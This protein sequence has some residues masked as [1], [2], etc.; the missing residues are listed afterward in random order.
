[1]SSK[2]IS[3]IKALVIISS[4]DIDKALTGL[5]WATNALK[6]K[7]ASDVKVIFFGPIEKELSLGNK[8]LLDALKNYNIVSN[9]KTVACKFIAEQNNFLNN[10]NLISSQMGIDVI[11][12]GNKVAFLLSQG[13]IPLVF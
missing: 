6:Y 12:A 10:L 3:N 11:Y 13:Y 7:W 1:M 8:R 5:L 4:S 9:Q 2:D